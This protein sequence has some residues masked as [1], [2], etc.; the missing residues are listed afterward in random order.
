M[1]KSLFVY[2]LAIAGL[3]VVPTLASAQNER[4]GPRTPEERIAA[5]KESLKLTDDQVAKL[6]PIFA[7][8]AEKTKAIREDQSLSQEDRRA[9]MQELFKSL[10]EELKPVLTPE[11]QAKYKEDVEKRRQ[12]RGQRPNN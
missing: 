8:N 6:K 2:S 10:D 12:Q 11:Q 4:R 9:K 7:K 1:K 5:M 3:F